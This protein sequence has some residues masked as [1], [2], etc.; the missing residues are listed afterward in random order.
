VTADGTYVIFTLGPGKGKTR[1]KN[2]T[3]DG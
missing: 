1:E 3:Q 2:C